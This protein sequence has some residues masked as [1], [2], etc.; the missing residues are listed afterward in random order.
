MRDDF[1]RVTIDIL[2]K[3]V[4]YLCSNPNCRRLT[5]GA[6]EIND[7][8]TSIGNAAH[9]TAAASGGPRF[10]ENITHE[11]R[12][13]IDNG[14]WLCSNCATLIDRDPIRFSS[15]ILLKW[16]QV[17]EDET[18]EKITGEYNSQSNGVPFLEADL[19]HSSSLRRN[20]G[21]SRK[22]P[23]E[24]QNGIPVYICGDM[25]IIHWVLEWNFSFVIYNNSEFT[26]YNLNVE[27]IGTQHFIHIDKLPKINN[28]P[29]LKNVDLNAK[30][31][32]QIESDHTVADAI[33]KPLIPL[34]FND[35]ILRITCCDNQRQKHTFY[36]EFENGE[37]INRKL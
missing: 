1:S 6:N 3:R 11:Q 34:K 25:P 21:Y 20:D 37:I 15:K 8:S 17:A 36:V 10:E 13:H 23:L 14:I 18:R 5:I 22:N 9:I 2:A 35:L 32:D 19:I 26:A 7:K 33:M 27:S 12:K 31:Q 16:K 29:P 24:I 30:Y 28:L 4:G